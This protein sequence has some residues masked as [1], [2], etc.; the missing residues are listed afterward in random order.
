VTVCAHHIMLDA[1][2]LL[3]SWPDTHVR[4]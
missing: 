4:I 3:C 1:A 2:I